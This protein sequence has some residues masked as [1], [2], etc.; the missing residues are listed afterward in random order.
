MENENGI[1]VIIFDHDGTLCDSRD[2]H[3][4]SLNQALLIFGKEYVISKEEHLSTF[5]GLNTTKKLNMLTEKRRLPKDLHN[6]IWELKQYYTL[7]EIEKTEED[8]RLQSILCELK[9]EGYKLYVASNSIRDTIELMLIKKGIRQY[10][11]AIYSNQDVD[12]PKPNPEIYLRCMIE[13]GV[14][15]DNTLIVE[16][17]HIGRKAALASGAHLCPVID[18]NDV[19]Y[20]KIKSYLDVYDYGKIPKWQGGSMN[21][22][23]PMAGNGSRFVNAGY[24]FPKPLIPINVLGGKPMI[25]M[26][27]ENLNVEAKFIYIVRKEHYDKY[28]L[29]TLL[30]LIT[31]NC[32]IVQVDEVTEGAACT[33]LLAEKYINNDSQL[34]IAN[35]DQFVEWE[36]NEFFYSMQADTIDAGLATFK[37]CHPRWSFAKLNDDGFVSEVAE[38]NPISDNA[39]VGFYWFKSGK[40]FVSSAKRMIIQDKRI[41]GEFYVCP[42]LNEL[43]TDGKKVK[44]FPVKKM[45]GTGT[46]EDLQYFEENYK[47]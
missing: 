30:N 26:V 40:D 9:S 21:V 17:S 33:V 20:E 13:A 25:Q 1:K 23:I 15:P 10:F 46:P 5:D 8:K 31:P 19:T 38:K 41:N 28:N 11:E 34:F 18:S 27:V 43:I 4:T 45:F 44:I 35:S 12:R 6:K 47:K 2:I 24:T 39:S 29:Q 37:S 32:E 42:V 7:K 22:V 14:G 16:D 36:S 3:Y